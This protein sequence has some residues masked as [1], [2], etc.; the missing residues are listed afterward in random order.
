MKKTITLGALLVFSL[1]LLSFKQYDNTD[2]K[3]KTGEVE[4]NGADLFAKK[5]CNLCHDPNKVIVGPSLKEIASAYKGD[6]NAILNFLNGK[7]SPIVV[8]E[9]FNYMKP[10]LN[11]LKNMNKEQRQALAE[12]IAGHK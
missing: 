3:A 12:F 6:K 7:G 11:Q 8:P 4:V 2:Y 1:A 5:A 10:V 9:E